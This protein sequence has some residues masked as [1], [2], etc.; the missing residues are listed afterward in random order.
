MAALIADETSGLEL[1]P[2]ACGNHSFWLVGESAMVFA[3]DVWRLLGG[4]LPPFV[5][6][7]SV[8][9]GSVG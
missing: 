6:V 7:W 8:G 3:T 4:V 5:K 2:E 9:G 1:V